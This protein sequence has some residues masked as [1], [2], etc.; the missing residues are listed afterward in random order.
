MLKIF[1]VSS[2]ITTASAIET[3]RADPVLASL[4]AGT[5]PKWCLCTGIHIKI[6][7]KVAALD[8]IGDQGYKRPLAVDKK[9]QFYCEFLCR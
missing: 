4:S 2:R 7:P 5:L 1:V 6:M 8:R 3:S 9:F